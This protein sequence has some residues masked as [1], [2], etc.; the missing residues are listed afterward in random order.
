MRLLASPRHD[1]HFHLASLRAHQVNSLICSFAK[2]PRR[3]RWPVSASLRII[4]SN[5]EPIWRKRDGVGH[6]GQS[7]FSLPPVPFRSILISGIPLNDTSEPDRV[8][9]MDSSQGMGSAT[10]WSHLQW[11]RPMMTRTGFQIEFPFS[12]QPLVSF[13]FQ[14]W[15]CWNQRVDNWE[16]EYSSISLYCLSIWW[17]GFYGPLSPLSRS[18]RNGTF[19]H[20]NPCGA[21]FSTWLHRYL[22]WHSPSSSWDWLRG[23]Y[24]SELNYLYWLQ[25]SRPSWLPAT[26]ITWSV[27]LSSILSVH[28]PPTSPG[29]KTL[30][31]S[32]T[33]YVPRSWLLTHL[34]EYIEYFWRCPRP[35]GAPMETGGYLSCWFFF[36]CAYSRLMFQCGSLLPWSRRRE[37]K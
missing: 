32:F 35:W 33:M 26:I 10:H 6:D 11:Q 25:L 22:E 16:R 14:F 9:N 4:F 37:S 3:S 34:K 18:L 24:L 8:I 17:W 36:L 27:S 28:L 20:G 13:V 15:W 1:S 23:K 21:G 5:A 12:L 2:L 29:Q 19:H 30:P 7:R 31:V